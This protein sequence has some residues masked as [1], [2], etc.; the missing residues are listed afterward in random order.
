[1]KRLMTFAMSLLL[2]LPLAIGCSQE[3]STET[4]RTVETPQGETTVRTETTVE[5][6]GENPPPANP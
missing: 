1:M 4:T 5:Q 2:A 3:S 6:S